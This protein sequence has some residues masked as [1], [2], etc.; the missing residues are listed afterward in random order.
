MNKH[1]LTKE[2]ASIFLEKGWG[3]SFSKGNGTYNNLAGGD[4]TIVAPD[5]TVANLCIIVRNRM[6]WEEPE[7]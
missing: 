7:Q 1:E 3:I 2:M 5:D 6:E 4:L